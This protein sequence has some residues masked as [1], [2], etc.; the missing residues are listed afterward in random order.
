MMNYKKYPR[1]IL[2]AY[3]IPASRRTSR[4]YLWWVRKQVPLE[5]AFSGHRE[6]NEN[7]EILRLLG[8]K[9]HTEA[10]RA[11]AIFPPIL[12]KDDDPPRP[13]KRFLND[14]LFRVISLFS[15]KVQ[16]LLYDRLLGAIFGKSAISS[17]TGAVGRS[18]SMYMRDDKQKPR[19]G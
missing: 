8:Y 3:P 10:G 15:I 14:V 2:S 5:T 12:C 11:Y 9:T 7:R 4:R 16:I 1:E 17:V 18:A 6:R 19:L 13:S